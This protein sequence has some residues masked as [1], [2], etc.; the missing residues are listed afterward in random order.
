MRPEA[1]HL[2]IRRMHCCDAFSLSQ[3]VLSVGSQ[4]VAWIWDSRSA[5]ATPPS[6]NPTPGSTEEACRLGDMATTEG[7]EPGM[8][9]LPNPLTAGADAG[10]AGAARPLCAAA[11]GGAE[12][13][14]VALCPTGKVSAKVGSGEAPLP[15]PVD[16]SPE[17]SAMARELKER[18][19][20]VVD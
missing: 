4:D 9:A 19:E 8:N 6:P 5:P 13:G 20:T 3:S 15:C 7:K 17:L 18:S 11:A 12:A 1:P 14:L 10:G 16:G 2:L